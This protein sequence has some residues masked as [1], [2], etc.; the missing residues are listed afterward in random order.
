M[1][2]KCSAI[3][4]R[5]DHRIPGHGIHVSIDF[6]DAATVVVAA[7]YDKGYGALVHAK[8][9]PRF[10][11]GRRRNRSGRGRR[12]DVETIVEYAEGEG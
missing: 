11:S 2:A 10:E 7:L 4:S 5:R 9:S 1:E 3:L 12:R 8:G 6:C